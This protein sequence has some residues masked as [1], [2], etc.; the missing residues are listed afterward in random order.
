MTK[1]FISHLP[2]HDGQRGAAIRWTHNCQQAFHQGVTS[3]QAWLSND[4]TG[5]LW[6]NL[7]V[8]RDALPAG[9]Q[10]RAFEVGFLSRVHQRLCS[11]Y[12]GS[13]QARRTS[14]SL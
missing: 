4:D 13:H 6:A 11:P 9:V 1:P 12:G 3:A 7:I 14:L 2:S 10:R 5:W 8:E